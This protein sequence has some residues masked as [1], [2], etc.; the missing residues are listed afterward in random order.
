MGFATLSDPKI[1]LAFWIGAISILLT[2]ILLV[3]IIRIRLEFYSQKIRRARFM[4]E[5]QPVLLKT[6][7][8]EEAT[9]PALHAKSIRDFL[10]LWL[11]LQNTLR[12]ESRMQLNRLLMQVSVKQ[13]TLKQRLLKMLKSHKTDERL[14]ALSVMGFL[15]D[16]AACDDLI[17]ALQDPQ[18]AIA[19]TAAHALLRIDDGLA[20]LHVIPMIILKR[21][22]SID[23]VALILEEASPAFV[24]AFLV[25]IEQAEIEGQPYLLR[26]MRVLEGLQLNRPL[27]F[28]RHILEHSADAELVTSALKLVQSTKDLDL[29]RARVN[30]AS[31]SVQVQV[32]AV[33][34]RLGSGE[35]VPRLVTMMSAK[36]WWVRYRAAKSLVQL[37]FVNHDKIESI[38]QNISDAYGRE[39]LSQVLAEQEKS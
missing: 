29:V 34:G 15:G 21:D 23:T 5:W 26:L 25:T 39:I 28:L 4:R 18:P 13:F 31:W 16:K 37:P 10:L 24:E 35:D 9:L 19:V 22:W 7:N 1:R 6:I 2:I 17:D 8:G 20:I 36:D 38:K 33:L 11:R 14:V 27:S 32:A 30:D 3:E 12:G